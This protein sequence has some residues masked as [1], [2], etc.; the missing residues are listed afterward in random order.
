MIPYGWPVTRLARVRVVRYAPG[1]M[2]VWHLREC[3]GRSGLL[4]VV[5]P[6]PD[7]V[8]GGWS[9]THVPSGL[10]AISGLTLQRAKAA[11]RALADLDWPDKEDP[12]A[13]DLAGVYDEVRKYRWKS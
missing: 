9:V 3:R 13:E 2:F 10:A 4:A 8:R 7:V 12:T 5:K 1:R 11:M 6:D